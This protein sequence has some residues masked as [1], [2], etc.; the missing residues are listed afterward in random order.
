MVDDKREQ[1]RRQAKREQLHLRVGEY[2][3][4]AVVAEAEQALAMFILWDWLDDDDEPQV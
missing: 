2:F 1:L 3:V 4:E